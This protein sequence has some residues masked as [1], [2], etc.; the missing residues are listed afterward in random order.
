[1]GVPC[2]PSSCASRGGQYHTVPFPAPDPVPIGPGS[3]CAGRRGTTKSENGIG[4]R[5]PRMFVF[6]L[7]TTSILQLPDQQSATWLSLSVMVGQEV[8]F[9]TR[10]TSVKIYRRNPANSWQTVLRHH[11]STFFPNYRIF[12]LTSLGNLSQN[13]LKTHVDADCDNLGL[14]RML[15]LIRL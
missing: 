8:Y 1:M 11:I 7:E 4:S 6:F 13:V 2:Y 12:V 9:I 14:Y 5:R 3:L 15:A 10:K